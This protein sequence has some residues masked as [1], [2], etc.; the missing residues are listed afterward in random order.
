M[1]QLTWKPELTRSSGLEVWW[2][3]VRQQRRLL[4]KTQRL[5]GVQ[6]AFQRF[7]AEAQ[8]IHVQTVDIDVAC[9]FAA[10][11]LDLLPKLPDGLQL[12]TQ[13]HDCC[14]ARHTVM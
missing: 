13:A 3:L 11:V 4:R 1:S 9:H 2:A 12:T 8:G 7:K 10:A 14:S 5:E 6:P